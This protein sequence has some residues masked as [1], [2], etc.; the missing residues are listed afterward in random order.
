LLGYFIEELARLKIIDRDTNINKAIKNYF[1][2]KK[3]N[4]FKD[5]IRQNRSGTGLNIKS[6]PIGFEAIDKILTILNSPLQ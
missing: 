1:L 3:G 2:D 6:K 4:S 5:S